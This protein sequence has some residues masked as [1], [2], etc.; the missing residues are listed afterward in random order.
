MYSDFKMSGTKAGVCFI[1]TG[2]TIDKDYPRVTLGYAFEIGD[3]AFMRVLETLHPTFV[4]EAIALLKKDSTELTTEDRALIKAT[5]M[6]SPFSKF[7]VTHGTDTM[8]ETA[9]Y[10]GE[11]PDKAI[12]I[13]GS[14]R[15]E[16]FSNS[17]A[18]VNLGVAIGAVQIIREVCTYVCNTRTHTNIS[19]RT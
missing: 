14:L 16:R 6:N 13:T 19:T 2:G 15:P 9:H 18:H 5:I 3:P 17:D 12:V 11:I 1:Q 10:L 7:V 4:Y 8:R